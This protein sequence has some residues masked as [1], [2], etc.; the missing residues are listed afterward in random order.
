MCVLCHVLC[1]IIKLC[2]L[3]L[4]SKTVAALA[5]WVLPK[6]WYIYT[7]QYRLNQGYH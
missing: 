1:V 7:E 3:L 5:D 6:D 4:L 2:L